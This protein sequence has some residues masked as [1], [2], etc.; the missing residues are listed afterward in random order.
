MC[1]A[2]WDLVRL[3]C[4]ATSGWLELKAGMD[5]L[6][7]DSHLCLIYGSWQVIAHLCAKVI[8]VPRVNLTFLVDPARNG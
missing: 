8:H 5:S 2:V 1:R 7:S 3:V 4:S 6:A